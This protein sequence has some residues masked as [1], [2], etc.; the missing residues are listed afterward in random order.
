[1][2]D[3][4][5]IEWATHTFNPWSGCT[6]VAEGCKF[7]YAEVNY[8]VKMR[9]V[10]WGPS[11][12]RIVASAA[13]WKEPLK[14]NRL[15]A[16]K[17]DQP[18]THVCRKCGT[19][20]FC[21]SGSSP[22]CDWKCDIIPYRPRV[23]CASLADVFEDWEGPILD[24]HG[25]TLHR[26]PNSGEYYGDTIQIGRS[27]VRMNDLRRDLFALIDA[28]PHLDWLILTKRPENIRRMWPWGWGTAETFDEAPQMVPT[29]PDGKL[30]DK[31]AP[32]RPNVWLLTSVATQADADKNIPELLKC[33]DL[34]PVL[35]VSAEP[36]IE[37]VDLTAIEAPTELQR[38]PNGGLKANTLSTD[39]RHY[40]EL[41]SH[42][43]WVIVGGESG[44]HARPC[45][46]EWIRSIVEQCQAANV[47][48]FVKQMGA[49]CRAA[50][51]DPS[52]HDMTVHG[53]V[54]ERSMQL[55]EN[56]Q[57][58]PTDEES[59]GQVMFKDKKGGDINEWAPEF[60]VRQF[61]VGV[62]HGGTES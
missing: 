40:Y 25:K 27:V 43:D 61:P 19:R 23:F 34:A 56:W 57:I 46:V 4:T 51:G 39:D 50:W 24:H 14:W 2:A 33:R 49:D 22:R 15:G 54:S 8:S 11:G 1:M 12:N 60:R 28:T 3:Q 42:L 7:C 20:Y 6:K 31:G 53:Q 17:G 44:P 35:G 29:F 45:R 9:G 47:P 10:Q 32:Y 55:G 38:S 62:H 58:K 18:E 13:M 5:K 16:S 48:C 41:G 21:Q 52:I 59:F 37:V 36:L 26:D 30:V